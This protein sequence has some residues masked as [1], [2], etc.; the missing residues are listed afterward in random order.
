MDTSILADRGWILQERTLSR[1]TLHWSMYEVSWECN[2][3]VASERQPAGHGGMKPY[4]KWAPR[5]TY[6]PPWKWFR[7]LFYPDPNWSEPDRL[8][9]PGRIMK[10]DDWHDLVRELSRRKLTYLS[11]RLPAMSGLANA[12]GKAVGSPTSSYYYG[13]WRETLTFDLC[14]FRSAI[15]NASESQHGNIVK[16]SDVPSFSWGS[17]NAPVEFIRPFSLDNSG[18]L[19]EILLTGQT[20]LRKP[21]ITLR[22]VV[23][24]VNTLAERRPVHSFGNSKEGLKDAMIWDVPDSHHVSTQ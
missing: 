23:F 8:M 6:E 22:G 21:S 17:I 7:E 24:D 16:S 19:V 4:R 10:T 2:E 12:F 1:R 3:I 18:E 20:S 15:P 9:Y 5:N 13:L 11:D 14:W